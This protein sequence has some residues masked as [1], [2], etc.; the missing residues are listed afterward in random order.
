LK[1]TLQGNH[2]LKS[3]IIK[4]RIVCKL[5]K[6]P[7]TTVTKP[8]I[9]L[10]TVLLKPTIVY[11]HKHFLHCSKTQT[12]KQFSQLYYHPKAK[13]TIS[14]LCDACIT[15]KISRNPEHKNVP[16]GKVRSFN[17]TAP[18]EIVSMDI[19]YFPTSS[20]GHTHGLLITDLYSMY[21]SFFPLK[22]KT[23]AA[24]AEALRT[25]FSLNGPPSIVYSDNDNSFL[26]ETQHIFTMFNVQHATSFPYSQKNNPVEGHVR[27]FK[28]ACRAAIS[29]NPVFSHRDWH[30]LYPPSHNPFKH[31]DYQIRLIK[32]S[33]S[34][35]KYF[36]TQ[37]APYLRNYL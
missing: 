32:G 28:N 2:Q 31:T 12:F 18:R 36:R 33:N 26:G 34:L 35:W 7:N 37:F 23:S 11:I 22:S 27:S 5:F 24:V 6:I 10:P 29:E 25:F 30:I 13:A 14:K 17:P 4:K 3:F 16:V 19:L 1:D 20:K 15:C 9:Y 8:V 21:L